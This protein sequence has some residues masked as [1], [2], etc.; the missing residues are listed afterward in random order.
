[1]KKFVISTATTLIVAAVL[2]ACNGSTGSDVTSDGSAPLSKA[3]CTSSNNWQSVGIGMSASQVQDR[4]GAPARTVVTTSNTEFQ[5]ERCRAGL[6]HVA[7]AVPAT[8]TT[9]GKEEDDTTY[10][11]GGSVVL[12]GS[13]GVLSINPPVLDGTKGGMHCE[14]DL[15]NYPFNY[16]SG[17]RECRDS[18]NP[19]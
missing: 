5:Y 1:M 11:F 19:F 18:N 15:Y 7:D 12:N 2:V 16:G 14:W 4:L 9:P 3:V 10:F 6:F 8:A 13:S 17:P